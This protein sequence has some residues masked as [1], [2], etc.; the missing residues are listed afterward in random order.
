MTGRRAGRHGTLLSVVLALFLTM[1]LAACSDEGDP[2]EEGT[3]G[4]SSSS[5][6]RE[7]TQ[8]AG[9][10]GS[11]SLFGLGTP[12]PT[13]EGES[14]ATDSTTAA[15]EAAE[16]DRAAW[17]DRAA[18]ALLYEAT[19][20]GGW[21]DNDGWLSDA[22]IGQWH[23]VTAD[24]D[25]RVTA[26]ILNGNNLVGSVPPTLGSLTALVQLDLGGN[27]LGGCLPANLKDQLEISRFRDP[28]P[29]PA[30]TSAATDREA[31]V[32]LRYATHNP[33]R[34]DDLSK[35]TGG[36]L[37][38]APLGEWAGVTT[39]DDESV[40]ELDLDDNQL[41]GEIPPWLG[42]L[43]NLESLKLGD[44]LLRGEIPPELGSLANLTELDL[45]F[46][47]LSGEIPPELGNLANLTDLNLSEDYLSGEI[48]PVLG[49]LAN[50]E[51]LKLGDNQLSGEIPPELGNLANLTWLDLHQNDLTGE[52][53]P[54]LGNLANL[55]WLDLGWNDLTGKIPPEL[56]SL[57]NLETLYL[58]GT[59]LGGCV[60][61]GLNR[62]DL[63]FRQP[64]FVDGYCP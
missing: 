8:E 23:G 22:P 50:L 12:G 9:S 26:L 17:V 25:G 44:N 30:Q 20:G 47:P 43:A 52:I 34:H 5:G 24:A 36:W 15:E 62:D 54:E 1:A 29:P 10:S 56:G 6:E 21:T 7:A 59:D 2:G 49:N 42:S 3:P 11:Q 57:A 64:I 32:A 53:P 39:N 27:Q 37:S 61:A 45:A 58:I 55:T 46:N 35:H 28:I 38:D 13:E 4:S 41:S 31:L 14:S 18:L 51:S 33:S 48:P 16:R 19:G 60:P 63:D 40:T